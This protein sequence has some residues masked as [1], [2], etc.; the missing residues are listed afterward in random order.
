M[1]EF[2]YKIIPASNS[3][4]EHRILWP[5]KPSYLELVNLLEP[6]LSG[7]F[8][9]LRVLENDEYVDMF[10]LEVME[11]FELNPAA[12]EIYRRDKVINEAANPE[13]MSQI[14]GPAVIFKE[15]VWF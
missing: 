6:M 11:D 3:P 9:H 10:V 1:K 14:G 4:T 2:V 13:L 12:T 7:P 5:V 15:K 8:T